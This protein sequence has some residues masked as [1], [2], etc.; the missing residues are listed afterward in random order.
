MSNSEDNDNG[1]V[2]PRCNTNHCEE[3]NEFESRLFWQSN[4][5]KVEICRACVGKEA[6]K[7]APCKDCGVKAFWIKKFD[8]WSVVDNLCTNCFLK[9]E[10][11]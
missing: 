1:R 6:D 7:P 11:D 10:D 2:C 4:I 9:E 8:R 5:D 3:D